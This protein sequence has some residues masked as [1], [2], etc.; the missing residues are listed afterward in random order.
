VLSEELRQRKNPMT[1][2]GIEPATFRF[3]AQNLN[4]CATAPPFTDYIMSEVET[5]FLLVRHLRVDAG[6]PYL[7]VT[8]RN[9]LIPARYTKK[10]G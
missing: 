4:H 8:T 9:K 7:R 3:V 2:S 5:T 10:S 1:P 6:R